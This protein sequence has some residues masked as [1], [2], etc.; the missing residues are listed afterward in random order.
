MKR[1][2]LILAIAITAS[3]Q[4]GGRQRSITHP[5]Q[6]APDWKIEITTSGGITGGGTGGLIVSANG[7]LTITFGSSPAARRCTFQLTPSELQT[8][9]ARVENLRPR[10]WMECYSLA[11]VGTHC[12]DLI[13][14]N[15]TLSARNGGD[16]YITSWLT[17]SELPQDL[18]DLIETLKGPAGV[19][20]RY[21]QLCATQ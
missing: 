2:M 19:D 1:V 5:A 9:A 18:R 7:A 10:S 13:R 12:C 20:S 3:A 21:R 14:T 11:N 4:P 8:L 6:L 17:G 16:L 15:L